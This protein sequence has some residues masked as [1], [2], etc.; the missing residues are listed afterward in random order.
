[1]HLRL[2]VEYWFDNNMSFDFK[3]KRKIQHL[4]HPT[5]SHYFSYNR[6][7]VEEMEGEQFVLCTRLLKNSKKKNH[8]T[9]QQNIQ[10]WATHQGRCHMILL[11][12]GGKP[13]YRSMQKQLNE[14]EKSRI[15]GHKRT[16]VHNPRLPLHNTSLRI[17]SNF[18]IIQ[19]KW[20]IQHIKLSIS[21]K[22]HQ[23]THSSLST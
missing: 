13:Y 14:E 5:T 10:P 22:T 23:H 20:L 17:T 12:R 15:A 9:M 8:N 4:V 16:Y 6:R 18:T 21:C 11:K 19:P 7:Q 3:H 2:A 1:M